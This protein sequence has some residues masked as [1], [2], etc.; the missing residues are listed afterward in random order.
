MCKLSLWGIALILSALIL[1]ACS[2]T[3]AQSAEDQVVVEV[4][5][6]VG[7]A[8]DAALA[9][10]AENYG[11]EAPAAG[12][13]WAAKHTKPEGLVGGESYTYTA[14]DW[15]IAISY[16]VVAPENVIYTIQVSN[17]ATGFR[18]EGQVDA[19][20]QV[21]EPSAPAGEGADMVNPASAYCEQQG[22][23]LEIVT[24]ADG[25]QSGVCVFPDGSSCDEWA[26]FRGECEPGAAPATPE[27]A[28]DGCK[29]YRNAELGYRFHYPADAEIII[30]DDPLKSISVIG[31]LVDNEWWPQITVSHPQDRED[32][33]PPEGV[34]LRQWLINHYLLGPEE[35]MPDAQI[36]GT[37][38][39]HLRHERSPQSYAFDRY[40]FARANQLYEI[41]ISHAG[42]KEDWALYN[43]FLQSF[44]FER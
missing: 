11:G 4:P 36:A 15:V 37:T 31:P 18:W 33:R 9:Y 14:G 40:Y 32:C 39:I 12:L 28:G 27:I 20:G 43:H 41:T 30:N 44:R 7:A 5:Q 2:S 16:P 35:G 24:A 38:A 13:A 29:I 17:Q 3:Q 25:S 21:T 42:D 6:E 34:D 19:Q 1:G 8:R 22:Y 10:L 26:Y 23:Q